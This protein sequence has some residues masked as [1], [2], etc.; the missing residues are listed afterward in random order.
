MPLNPIQPLPFFST[1]ANHQILSH[2]HLLL[3]FLSLTA[4][5]S[6]YISFQRHPASSAFFP[7]SL[8]VRQVFFFGT[9][10][11]QCGDSLYYIQPL[12]TII[13]IYNLRFTFY[14]VYHLLLTTY[15]D[16]CGDYLY[17]IQ[18]PTFIHKMVFHQNIS[19]L[20]RSFALTQ[21]LRFV[22]LK[23][24]SKSK[25]FETHSQRTKTICS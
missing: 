18:P 5:V 8:F 9:I 17:Y 22:V 25:F 6:F 23:Q 2:S 12:F 7:N 19:V 20:G 14:H 16:Q 15:T 3:I 24:I 10:T 1:E 21:V 4:A 13:I 11:D